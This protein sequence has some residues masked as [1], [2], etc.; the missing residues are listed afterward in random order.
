[1]C[2]LQWLFLSCL[3]LP[4]LAGLFEQYHGIFVK[5]IDI[6]SGSSRL[7]L[8]NIAELLTKNMVKFLKIKIASKCYKTCKYDKIRELKF[9]F[10]LT[11]ISK[12][13]EN[14]LSRSY[15]SSF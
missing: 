9:P 5:N 6:F 10:F 11:E 12:M 13:R 14:A 4:P 15:S 8:D 1:M 7:F 3:I 2:Q